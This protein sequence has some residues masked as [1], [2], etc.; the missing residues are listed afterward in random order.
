MTERAFVLMP[1]AD[2][3]PDLDIRGRKVR[4]W[5]NDVD[6]AGIEVADARKDWWH[7]AQ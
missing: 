4:E 3:A 2:I 1:L 5:L 7:Q 6:A